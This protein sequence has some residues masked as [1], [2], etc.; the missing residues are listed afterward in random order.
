VAHRTREIAVR[1]AFGAGSRDVFR[2]VLTRALAQVA[3]GFTLGVVAALGWSRLFPSGRAG[4]SVAD[5]GTLAI[6]G[7]L[8]VAVTIVAIAVPSIRATRLD[9]LVALRR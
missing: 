3:L 1:V 6:V 7:L 5:P 2:L 9:P 8:L 4:V